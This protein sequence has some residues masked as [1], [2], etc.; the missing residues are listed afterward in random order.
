[1]AD[2]D[3]DDFDGG[4]GAP[5]ARHSQV[6][7][8]I[9][10]AGAACSVALVVTLGLWGYKL[11]VRDVNGIPVVRAMEGPMRIAPENPGGEVAAHQGLAVNAIAAAGSSEAM[12]ERLVLA[13]RPVELTFE[14]EPGLSPMLEPVA[15]AVD[16]PADA[17]VTAVDVGDNRASDPARPILP[18]A[19]FATDDT[20]VGPDADA[21]A[22]ALAEALAGDPGDGA[23]Q[24]ASLNVDVVEQPATPGG[25]RPKA[26]P[27]SLV[28]SD[29]QEVV[30][31][32]AVS[33]AVTDEVDAATISAGT[34]LVQLGA[35][36]NADQARTEWAV[37]SSKF[38]SEIAG[39]SL[40]I[41]QAESGGRS[42]YRLRAL[43]FADETAARDFCTALLE[44]NA[45]CIPVVVR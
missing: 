37:L 17:S 15:V 1:M 45:A 25:V 11:A 7:K 21:V 14:D 32:V 35:F 26:R 10:L 41:Q 18:E 23:V 9:N 8:L 42:F 30:A 44:K 20:L 40:V 6:S 38:G 33:T 39:K 5:N 28:L 34:R 13:P 4:Y 29:V 27:A 12:P 22:N 3:F 16:L 24:L 2:V 36:D 43:G 19:V 31:P